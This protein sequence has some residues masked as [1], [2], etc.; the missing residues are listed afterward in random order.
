MSMTV[1]PYQSYFGG[2][3]SNGTY[4]TIINLIP[5]H[6]TFCSL[7]L[8][9]CA[10]TRHIKPALTGILNDLDA[11][12]CDAWNYL[13]IIG[14]KGEGYSDYRLMNLPALEVL[15]FLQSLTTGKIFIYLDPPYLKDTR[16]NQAN[17]Y[18]FEMTK[19]QHVELLEK[20]TA[21]PDFMIMISCYPNDLYDMYLH[22]WQYKDFYSTIRGGVALERVYYNYE[23]TGE[24]HDNR[25]FGGNFREREQVKRIKN[26][27]LKKMRQLPDSIRN[28]VI[29]EFI[30]ELNDL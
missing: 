18:R 23:F 7:F 29:Q 14:K 20:I 25:Y 6:D 2:K 3:E 15:S 16:K 28:A 17:V 26:S 27:L 9:N 8:G 30:G 24:L 5:P 21:M 22:E 4:Q 1:K 11:V 19:A 12:V 13:E 10:I